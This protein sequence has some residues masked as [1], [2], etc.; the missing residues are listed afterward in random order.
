MDVCGRA[1][2]QAMALLDCAELGKGKGEDDRPGLAGASQT[3][4]GAVKL[5]AW[6]RVRKPALPLV[7]GAGPGRL[8]V[9]RWVRPHG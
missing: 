6:S 1:G 3:G 7:T 9:L 5:V 8:R 4:T 2:W